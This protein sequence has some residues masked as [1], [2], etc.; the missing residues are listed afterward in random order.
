LL[1]LEDML[2]KLLL[3]PFIGIVNTKLLKTRSR[4]MWKEFKKLN[5]FL[6]HSETKKNLSLFLPVNFENLE[7]VDVEQTNEPLVFCLFEKTP[8]Y[9]SDNP[10]EELGVQKLCE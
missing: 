9:L 6:F 10:V 3:Q 4:K 5:I 1:K 7:S 8:V 2:H